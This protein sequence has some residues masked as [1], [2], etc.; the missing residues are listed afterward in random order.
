MRAPPATRACSSPAGSVVGLLTQTLI[1]HMIR[2]PKVPF[3]QSIAAPPLLL[4]TGLIAAIGVALP[5]SPLAGYFKQG[6][7][8]R[9]L[10]VPGGDPVR[11]CGADHR[12][13][14]LHPPVR[15]AVNARRF[16][17]GETQW[18]SIEPAGVQ[19]RRNPEFADQP[20]GGVRAGHGHRPGTATAPTHR[21]PAYQHAGGGGSGGVRRSGRA[22]P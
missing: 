4:M 16:V 12:A 19:R 10:A 7:A 21:R 9:L 18:T 6:A 11:L 2:T 8:G 15:L 5:M 17:Q 13:E 3:L 22:L 20:V 1:V 14:V